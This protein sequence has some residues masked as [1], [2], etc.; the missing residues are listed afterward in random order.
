VEGATSVK[1]RGSTSIFERRSSHLVLPDSSDEDQHEAVT[2]ALSLRR[3]SRRLS[4]IVDLEEH[5]PIGLS[6]DAVDLSTTR[7]AYS[8]LVS[9][10][11]IRSVPRQNNDEDGAQA[12]E[13]LVERSVNNEM[14]P[15]SIELLTLTKIDLPLQPRGNI[16]HELV[17][18]LTYCS[19]FDFFCFFS[20]YRH[21]WKSRC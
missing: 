6:E 2:A 19:V 3:R 12:R 11:T 4:L 21:H 9:P 13:D 16:P 1:R 8:P 20:S 17:G 7:G 14:P 10:I 15:Y 18:L 5:K